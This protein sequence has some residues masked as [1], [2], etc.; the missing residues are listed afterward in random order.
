MS[1]DTGSIMKSVHFAG[2]LGTEKIEILQNADVGVVNPSGS[3][4]VCPGSALEIQACGTPVV[5]AAKWGLLDTVLHQETGLL[6]NNDK[7]LTQNIL[8]LLNHPTEAKHLGTNGINFVKDNFAPRPIIKQWFN[9]FTDIYDNK[10]PQPQP[11]KSNYFY[12]AKFVREGMCQLKNAVPPLQHLP[13]LIELELL[14]RRVGRKTIQ[15]Y[16]N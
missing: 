2:L 1:D 9:L 13:A 16:K 15:K 10:Q 3:T 7:M 4:E 11:M 5:S 14:L 8:Y 12:R 6:A